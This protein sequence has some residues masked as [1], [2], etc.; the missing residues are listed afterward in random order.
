MKANITETAK[1]SQKNRSLY[2]ELSS[3]RR[4]SGTDAS[5]LSAPTMSSTTAMAATVYTAF[6]EL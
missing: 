6:M 2:V 1:N 3:R 4:S 5:T